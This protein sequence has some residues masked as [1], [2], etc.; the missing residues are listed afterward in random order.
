M[1]IK[2]L[3]I[4]RD[5]IPRTR[6]PKSCAPFFPHISVLSRPIWDK[7]CFGGWGWGG[8]GFLA[9]E[10]GQAYVLHLGVCH[11]CLLVGH[12]LI[13]NWEILKKSKKL[14]KHKFCCPT[15]CSLLSNVSRYNFQRNS[16]ESMRNRCP[17]MFQ[18]SICIKNYRYT[19]PVAVML[20]D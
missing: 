19:A 3:A 10:L 17:A 18:P 6:A 2:D 16:Q 4:S 1:K 14:S 12:C 11:D 7:F 9:A 20:S 5:P 13:A 8:V 15:H